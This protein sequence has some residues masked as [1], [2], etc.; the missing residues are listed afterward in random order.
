EL[1]HDDLRPGLAE[2]TLAHELV[3]GARGLR[4]RSTD[5]DALPAREPVRLDDHRRAELADVLLRGGQIAEHA[6]GRARHVVA[7]T[8]LLGERLRALQTSGRRPRAEGGEARLREAVDEPERERQLRTDDRQIDAALAREAL[9][10]REVVDRDRH[11]VRVGGDAGVAGRAV[12]SVHARAL[13]ELPHE[14]VLATASADDE[15]PHPPLSAG[16][17]GRR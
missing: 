12:E 7:A 13:A 15:D 11:A 3:D 1:L 10:A 2:R 16:S 8:E 6:E 14:R 5:E 4:H 9:Q 17:G